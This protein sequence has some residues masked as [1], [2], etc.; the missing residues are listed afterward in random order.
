VQDY[1]AILLM[2]ERYVYS[3]NQGQV[4]KWLRN[5]IQVPKDFVELDATLNDF[6]ED[7]SNKGF[8]P[9]V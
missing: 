9:K 6:F 7:M 3:S 4:S 2:D 8:V 1:G 5:K